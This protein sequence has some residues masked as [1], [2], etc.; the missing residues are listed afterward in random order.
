ML[1]HVQVLVTVD[2]SQLGFSVRG[3]L[4]KPAL[5]LQASRVTPWVRAWPQAR[6]KL[7]GAGQSTDK[8]PLPLQAGH[9]PCRLRLD[10]APDPGRA[11]S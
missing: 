8:R 6:P 7:P 11:P 9:R 3:V 10:P 5:A 4:P 2:C 1:S